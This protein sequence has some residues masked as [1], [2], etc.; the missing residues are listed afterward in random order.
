MA[1]CGKCKKSGVDVAHIR[2][3]YGMRRQASHP[4]AGQLVAD[5]WTAEDFRPMALASAP[6]LKPAPPAEVP[7]SKYAVMYNGE[8]MFFQV[9][10]PSKGKWAGYT[11]VNRLIGAP[12]SWRKGKVGRVGAESILDTIRS[13][14]YVDADPDGERPDRLLTGPAAGVVR[15]SRKFKRCGHCESPLS[16]RE[17]REFGMGPV[18]EERM[19][20]RT[21][22]QRIKAERQLVSA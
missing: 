14:S 2:E 1:T 9:D 7:A 17:S 15:Y 3:C 4:T 11:F 20:G 16:D 10:R 19:T 13:D 12:G 5:G 6:A 21:R 18:C 8:L 22:A